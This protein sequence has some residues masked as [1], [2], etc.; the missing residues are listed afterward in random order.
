[1]DIV[2]WLL[3]E[4]CGLEIG[5]VGC[6]GGPGRVLVLIWGFGDPSLAFRAPLAGG[7]G[8]E[9][10][11]W[12]GEDAERALGAPRGAARLGGANRGMRLGPD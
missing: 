5:L 12:A 6:D 11:G 1:M 10:A 4:G 3:G 8:L 7:G 2:Y 9:L